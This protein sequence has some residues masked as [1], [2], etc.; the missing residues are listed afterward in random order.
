M[1]TYTAYLEGTKCEV[2]DGK[3]QIPEDVEPGKCRLRLEWEKDGAIQFCEKTIQVKEP[4]A[5]ETSGQE[6]KAADEGT[7][8]AAEAV[9]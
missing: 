2:K 8:A 6:S 4:A 5:K 7:E 9:S 1:K 3:V